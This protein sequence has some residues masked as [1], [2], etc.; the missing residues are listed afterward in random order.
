MSRWARPS[1][2]ASA[3]VAMQVMTAGS[4]ASGSAGYRSRVCWARGYAVSGPNWQYATAAPS[5]TRTFA[6]EPTTPSPRP[7][8]RSLRGPSSA[9]GRAGRP[10]RGERVVG[11]RVVV[12]EQERVGRRGS[13]G[14]EVG[15]E[16]VRGCG[17]RRCRRRWSARA[18]SAS[19]GGRPW[20]LAPRPPSSR[21]IDG[22]TR[23]R[24]TAG[25]ARRWRH[26]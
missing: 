11:E 25:R 18:G 3:V 12:V 20:S 23:G 2:R 24:R 17:W 4:G 8:S 14:L 1:P 13:G 5:R 19:R 7:R 21:T 9:D 22:R 10:R 6:Y 15:E 26:R 16:R